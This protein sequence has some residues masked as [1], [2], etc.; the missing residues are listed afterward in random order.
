M[1]AIAIN[2]KNIKRLS[3]DSATRFN[4]NFKRKY[5]EKGNDLFGGFGGGFVVGMYSDP[6][7][8]ITDI[9]QED[10]QIEV[11]YSDSLFGTAKD[12]A[13]QEQAQNKADQGCARYGKKATYLDGQ[14]VQKG[15]QYN[16]WRAVAQLIFTC[17]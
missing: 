14:V 5:Y 13:I 10:I 4:I 7:A 1:S 12:D 6:V 2:W 16:G 9:D 3:I 17:D 11:R 15:T 8:S